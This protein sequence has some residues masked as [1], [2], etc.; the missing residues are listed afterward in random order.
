MKCLS[1]STGILDAAMVVIRFLSATTYACIAA[2]LIW[3]MWHYVTPF[4]M[5]LSWFWLIVA[6]LSLFTTIMGIIGSLGSLLT[7]PLALLIKSNT[8]IGILPALVY[9]FFCYASISTVIYLIIYKG[10]SFKTIL[11]S[12]VLIINILIIYV[13]LIVNMFSLSK[14]TK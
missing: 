9:A 1:C 14:S 5:S 12:I 3:Q 6:Y 10:P 7:I 2:L 4:V 13:V 8:W 11:S